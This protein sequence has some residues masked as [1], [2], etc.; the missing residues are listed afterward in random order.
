MEKILLLYSD[1]DCHFEIIESVIVDYNKILKTNDTCGIYIFFD[2]PATLESVIFQKYITSKYSKIKFENISHY[3][4]IINITI[5]PENYEVLCDESKRLPENY[6]AIAHRIDALYNEDPNVFYLTELSDHNIFHAT[7]LPFAKYKMNVD[8]PIIVVQGNI[9][10]QRRDY[11]TLIKLLYFKSPFPYKIKVLGRG[12]LSTDKLEDVLDKLIITTDLHFIDYHKQF[13]DCYAICPLI[14]KE[15]QPQYYNKTMTSSI[16]YAKGYNLKTFLDDD[17]QNIYNLNNAVTYNNTNI[18]SQFSKLLQEFYNSKAICGVYIEPRDII[19]V[20]KNIENFN[21]NVPG[22]VIYFFCGKGLAEKYRATLKGKNIKLIE[23]NVN[24]LDFASYSNLMK[25]QQFW[26]YFDD[27]YT[28]II[29]IQSDGCFCNNSR[30][31][32][33]DFIHYDYVGGFAHEGWWWKETANLHYKNNY[34]CFNGGISLRNIKA[35]KAIVNKYPSSHT[36]KYYNGCP[37]IY[38]PEDLYFVT[39]MIKEGYNVGTDKFATLF[40]SHTSFVP[41]CLTIHKINKYVKQEEMK[42]ILDYCPEF[43]IFM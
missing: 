39:G 18:L 23:L 41:H 34:Q 31:S 6:F 35:C 3:D 25:S 15:N 30:L 38:Y 24:N 33:W 43:E 42:T 40:C 8:Y 11:N 2:F 13:V 16:N 12:K 36:E 29:T 17:L 9:T 20:Y 32:I 4:Y 19:Q 7:V 10:S 37:L 27:K 26:N 21:K 5:Y 22:S 14:S 28:H 1:T